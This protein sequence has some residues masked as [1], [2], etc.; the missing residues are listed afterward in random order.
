VLN[1]PQGQVP[2]PLPGAVW[3]RG[4]CPRRQRERARD[5]VLRIAMELC[6]PEL[7]G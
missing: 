6:S 1:D 5:L 3:C 4:R 2:R 7:A